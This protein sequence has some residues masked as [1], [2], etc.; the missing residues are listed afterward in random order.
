MK[1]LAAILL[2]TL[3]LDGPDGAESQGVGIGKLCEEVDQ[4]LTCEACPACLNAT[5]ASEPVLLPKK[6]EFW[7]PEEILQRGAGPDPIEADLAAELAW[8]EETVLTALPSAVKQ[9]DTKYALTEIEETLVKMSLPECK[10]QYCAHSTIQASFLL[11]A[12]SCPL[13]Y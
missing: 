13:T 2:L 11:P 10:Y 1:L 7:P 6:S 9:S 5:C 12:V 3:A 8:F 4:S